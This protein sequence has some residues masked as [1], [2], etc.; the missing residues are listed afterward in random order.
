MDSARET[1]G[2]LAGPANVREREQELLVALL[3]VGIFRFE[4]ARVKLAGQILSTKIRDAVQTST[5]CLNKTKIFQNP[6]PAANVIVILSS[7]LSNFF[8][9]GEIS[10]REIFQDTVVCRIRHIVSRAAHIT[11]SQAWEKIAPSGEVFQSKQSLNSVGIDLSPFSIL[12]IVETT[13]GLSGPLQKTKRTGVLA[14]ALG[15][16]SGRPCKKSRPRVKNPPTQAESTAPTAGN[17]LL[18]SSHVDPMT[19]AA[20]AATSSHS[21]SARSLEVRSA[22][23]NATDTATS[24]T[25]D[26]RSRVTTYHRTSSEGHEELV[27]YNP[28][29]PDQWINAEITDTVSLEAE[30]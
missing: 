15:G 24:S 16:L 26:A 12:P 10:F 14:P 22:M 21:P 8:R 17:Q 20:N 25:T 19:T 9:G 18:P 1:G 23:P 13:E 28:D 7:N 30:R 4:R 29:E 11:T 27:F 2:S 3:V 6:A 5:W